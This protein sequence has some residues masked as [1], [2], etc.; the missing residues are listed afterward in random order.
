MTDVL[1]PPPPEVQEQY[2]NEFP[3]Q[4][5]TPLPQD[6][7][8]PGLRKYI[9]LCGRGTPENYQVIFSGYNFSET[10]QQL[11]KNTLHIKKI[12]QNDSEISDEELFSQIKFDYQNVE[13]TVL[14]AINFF[15]ENPEIAEIADVLRTSVHDFARETRNEEIVIDTSPEILEDQYARTMLRAIGIDE[16]VTPDARLGAAYIRELRR[17]VRFMDDFHAVEDSLNA[18]R[19]SLNSVAMLEEVEQQTGNDCVLYASYNLWRAARKQNAMLDEVRIDELKLRVPQ[20]ASNGYRDLSMEWSNYMKEKGFTISSDFNWH[21]AIKLIHKRE[22]GMVVRINA[23]HAIA[24][25][26]VRHT[27][28]QHPKIEFLLADSLDGTRPKW[29]KGEQLISRIGTMNTQNNNQHEAF[30]LTWKNLS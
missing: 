1:I 15:D 20:A 7:E 26:G 29:V 17:R 25:V 23:N 19:R 28:E 3:T 10:L 14:D 5:L 16:E 27:A 18:E 6:Q 9:E 4:E 30:L 22:A 12:L 11:L 8:L 2:K 13:V 24:V 21:E